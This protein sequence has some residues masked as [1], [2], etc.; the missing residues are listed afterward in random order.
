MRNSNRNSHHQHKYH[1]LQI[2][3]YHF[4][5]FLP[6]YNSYFGIRPVVEVDID[7]ISF[8]P[9][10]KLVSGNL[11]TVGS[12]VC[13]ENECFYIIS[14]T[15]KNVTMLAKYN[16]YAGGMTSQSTHFGYGSEA[17]G[18][19]DSTMKGY[20]AG[21]SVKNGVTRFS[22]SRYWDSEKLNPEYGSDYPAYVYDDNSLIYDY[23][24]KYK[25]Y[26]I[27]NPFLPFFYCARPFSPFWPL[28]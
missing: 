16:L 26:L 24:E 11:D 4:D 5:F 18:I 15:E 8:S 22:Q 7:E 20:V 14:S 21:E 9:V 17:T 2:L 25:K 6:T 19:Q 10:A 28:V 27:C 12:E 1:I 3:H 13:I 23:V